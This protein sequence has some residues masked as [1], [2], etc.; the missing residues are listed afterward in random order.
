[1]LSK[2]AGIV[3]SIGGLMLQ[4]RASGMVSGNWEGTQFKAEADSMAHRELTQRL[5]KLAPDIPIISEENPASWVTLR[6]ERYWLI[7]PIDGTASFAQGYDG[8]VTQVALMDHHTPVL[9]AIYAPSLDSLY[10]VEKGGG[11]FLNG[12]R[13]FLQPTFPPKTLIDNYPEPRGV[14]LQAFRELHLTRYIE[15]GGISLKIC[16]VADGTADL[17]FKVVIVRDWDLAA[18]HLLL[19]EAGGFLTDI[20]GDDI[21]YIG[22]F[23]REGLVAANHPESLEM[24]VRWHVQGS[25]KNF[26]TQK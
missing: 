16:N 8:F 15:R 7:D 25:Q 6:P 23:N 9:A 2:L 14:S 21:Q 13:L 22:S 19:K 5:T 4:W 20:Y 10:L 1:M 18:P 26:V 17:F 12:V 24:L 11:A 3:K